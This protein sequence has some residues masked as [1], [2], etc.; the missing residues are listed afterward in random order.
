MLVKVIRKSFIKSFII[1]TFIIYLIQGGSSEAIFIYS[2]FL[3][4]ELESCLDLL[5]RAF[6][7]FFWWGW[8]IFPLP[9]FYQ[10]YI[11]VFSDLFSE[12]W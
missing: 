4:G 7:I 11:F 12:V 3:K 9:G 2:C 10:C 6:D 5:R 8:I 1:L